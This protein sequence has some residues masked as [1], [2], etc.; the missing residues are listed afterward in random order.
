MTEAAHDK[1]ARNLIGLRR[2]V[3]EQQPAAA[4]EM[5]RRGANDEPQRRERIDSGRERAARLVAQ[6]RREE[7]RI[8]RRH[9][10]GIAQDEF[11]APPGEWLEPGAA[12]KLDLSLRSAIK[13]Q[14]SDSRISKGLASGNPL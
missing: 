8:I 7:R 11:E 12:K 13:K 1:F 5:L 6:A 14:E 4:C 2:A 3:L 9:V 10:R